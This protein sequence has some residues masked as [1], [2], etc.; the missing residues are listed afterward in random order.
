MHLI[1]QLQVA[2]IGESDKTTE[3]L[4]WVNGSSTVNGGTHITGL[5][6]IFRSA[7]WNPDVVLIHVI[8]HDPKF[9]GPSKDSLSSKEVID[10]IE[11]LVHKPVFEFR[12]MHNNNQN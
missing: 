7:N 4:S 11:E 9:A 5:K 8:M 2:A 1:V 6:S 10:T 12:K 3:Y